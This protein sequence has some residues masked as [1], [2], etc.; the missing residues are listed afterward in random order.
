MTPSRRNPA[1]EVVD[2]LDRL[3]DKG[4]RT[5]PEVG[6]LRARGIVES[7]RWMQGERRDGVATRDLLVGGAAGRLPARVYD[8]GVGAGAPLVVYLHGG[9]WVT[10]SVAVADRPCREIAA[11]SGAV[12][13]SVEYRRAPETPFP[14]PVE[15]ALAA[16]AWAAEHAAELGGDPARLVVAGDS[17][18]GN[19]AAATALMAR[20]RGGPTIARQVLVYPVLEPPD[21]VAHPSYA[22]NAEGFMLTAADMA[23]FWAHYL[24]GAAV[25]PEAAPLRAPDL[26]GLP[27]AS[28]AVAGLDPLRDEGIVYA[29]RLRSAGV[30]VR[31][32]EWEGL[33]HGFLW[34]AG[35][36]PQAADLVSWI[37][38]ELKGATWA[39]R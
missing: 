38:D 34:M 13:V 30:D 4:M 18:G 17:A 33:V 7:S 26:A 14:G 5:Y 10:G 19:L 20:D 25:V 8:P 3:R 23:W 24:D 1:P 2:L 16:T 9:G 37:G 21:P 27:P 28:I 11:A 32:R 35:E 12:V 15:D 36:L 29:E 6:V 39:S 31:L 22:E